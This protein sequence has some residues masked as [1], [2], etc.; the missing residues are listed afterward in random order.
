VEAAGREGLG[1]T[2]KS[3]SSERAHS[4]LGNLRFPQGPWTRARAGIVSRA[5]IFFCILL[6][7]DGAPAR[8]LSI[9][10]IREASFV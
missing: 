1:L 3:R 4:R 5:V 10:L 9:G 7:E 2:S 8:L 6:G